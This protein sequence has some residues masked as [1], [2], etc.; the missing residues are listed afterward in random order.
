[1]LTWFCY[2]VIFLR[3]INF[4][5]SISMKTNICSLTDDDVSINLGF[6]LFSKK[7]RRQK[8]R[9]HWNTTREAFSYESD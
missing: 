8:V 1:M 4:V 6:L 2:F 5:D 9:L 3:E 7:I